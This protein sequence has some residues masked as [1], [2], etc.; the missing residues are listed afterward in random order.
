MLS[1]L[2]PKLILEPTK[3]QVFAMQSNGPVQASSVCMLHSPNVGRASTMYFVVFGYTAHPKDSLLRNGS[4]ITFSRVII[5]TLLE[6]RELLL[7]DSL[8]YII[9]LLVHSLV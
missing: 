7:T 5:V 8:D 2:C 4:K 6:I 1:H 9:Y 3:G